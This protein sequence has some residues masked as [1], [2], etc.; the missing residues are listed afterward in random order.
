M[1]SLCTVGTSLN[2]VAAPRGPACNGGRQWI[3]LGSWPEIIFEADV[4]GTRSQ[5]DFASVSPFVTVFFNLAASIV[6][7]IRV[8]PFAH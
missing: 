5:I 4:Q 1:F 7:V 6:N 2:V 3:Y 8:Q